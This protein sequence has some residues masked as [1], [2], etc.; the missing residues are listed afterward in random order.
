MGVRLEPILVLPGMV[1]GMWRRFGVHAFEGHVSLEDMNRI[2]ASGSLWHRTNPGQLVELVVIYPSEARM[3]GDER[4][5][6]AAIV[7]RWEKTRTAS[8]T[9][10]LAEGLTGAMHRSVLT[11]LQMLAPPPHPSK[12][13][14][15]LPDAIAWL[16]PHVQTL[17]GPD[18]TAADLL[19]AT[20]RLCD[21]FRAGRPAKA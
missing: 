19:A 4:K 6:M 14:S 7:K 3:D 11:G 13:F 8:A 15:R 5:R 2:E 18:A 12:V 21:G 16:A 20:E 9:V 10:V 1:T 17:C